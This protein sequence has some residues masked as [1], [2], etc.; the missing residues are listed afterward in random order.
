MGE[1]VP[2]HGNRFSEVSSELECSYRAR[3]I[4]PVAYHFRANSYTLEA[5]AKKNNYSAE[6]L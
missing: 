4:V 5:H 6:A 1:L 3:S 2:R